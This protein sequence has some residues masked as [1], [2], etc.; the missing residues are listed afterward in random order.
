MATQSEEAVEA[1]ELVD[2]FLTGEASTML[3][4]LLWVLLLL[5]QLL[6]LWLLLL[7]QWLLLLLLA[8]LMAL[9]LLLGSFSGSA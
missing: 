8:I 4:L 6:L 9:L 5:L 3:L 7:L 2:S 1:S